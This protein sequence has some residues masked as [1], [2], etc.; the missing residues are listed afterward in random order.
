MASN[1]MDFEE[2]LAMITQNIR[3]AA[4]QDTAPSVKTASK[5]T[6]ERMDGRATE[7]Q[8]KAGTPE[9][10]GN[11]SSPGGNG[12]EDFHFQMV[13]ETIQER[14]E[15]GGIRK[16][17]ATL[18]P[19]APNMF[20]GKPVELEDWLEAV[21]I[22]LA[23]YGQADDRIMYMVVCLFLSADVKTWVKTLHIGS[24]VRLQRELQAYYV[25]PLDEDRA[26]NS[27]NKFQQTGSVKDY[28]EKF[29][30]LIVRVVSS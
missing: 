16:H 6:I 2:K 1:K 15:L 29:P 8:P 30:Q 20:T 10:G 13:A 28:S 27:L 18:R 12:D 3:S 14:V 4:D 22:Y 5:E 11:V 9:A 17:F 26:W 23:L 19:E 24:W 25:D 21:H 7:A